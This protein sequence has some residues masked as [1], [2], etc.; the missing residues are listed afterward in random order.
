MEATETSTDMGTAARNKAIL[1]FPDESP[2]ANS[3]ADAE[4]ETGFSMWGRQTIHELLVFLSVRCLGLILRV[5]H[6]NP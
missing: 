2:S 3:Q 6:K 4:D 5:T 1:A